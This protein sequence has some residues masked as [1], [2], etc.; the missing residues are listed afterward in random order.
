MKVNSK[1]LN[2]RAGFLFRKGTPGG[3]QGYIP[4][5]EVIAKLEELDLRVQDVI[6]MLAEGDTSSNSFTAIA[7]WW[8]ERSGDE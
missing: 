4:E 7:N 8:Y 1:D 2:T 3:E 5:E 6:C